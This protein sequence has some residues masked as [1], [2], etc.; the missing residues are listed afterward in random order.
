MSS[1]KFQKFDFHKI[2]D[3]LLFKTNETALPASWTTTCSQHRTEWHSLDHSP[4]SC[5]NSSE[6][7]SNR[8]ENQVDQMFV[9][10]RMF[11]PFR[12]RV[13][14]ILN[15]LVNLRLRFTKHQSKR[16][17]WAVEVYLQPISTSGRNKGT[18]S[19][20]RSVC[21]YPRW[22]SPNWMV[23]RFSP[24][25]LEKREIP[26]SYQHTNPEFSIV[27]CAVYLP[28]RQHG[29]LLFTFIISHK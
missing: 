29:F 1:S 8:N 13:A 9:V 4:F 28:Y 26:C 25:V 7:C 21:F 15:L 22:N 17:Y 27:Q 23:P 3:S 16:A 2:H 18:W 14:Q 24:D 20:S 5:S 11:R 12:I 10:G 19:A 6:Q